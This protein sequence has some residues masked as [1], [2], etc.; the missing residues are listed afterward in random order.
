MGV[1]LMPTYHRFVKQLVD[2]YTGYLESH[3]K[4]MSHDAKSFVKYFTCN[5]LV[6]WICNINMWNFT[7]LLTNYDN[8]G[9]HVTA[10]IVHRLGSQ[11]IL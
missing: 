3:S 8:Y 2:Y 5:G 4:L 9:S 6:L 7:E 10:G 11:I 1:I